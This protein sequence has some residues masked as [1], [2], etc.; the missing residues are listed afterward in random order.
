MA[1]TGDVLTR[2]TQI[3]TVVFDRRR[4]PFED[5]FAQGPDPVFDEDEIKTRRA[6][7]KTLFKNPA[8]HSLPITFEAHIVAPTAWV[9]SYKYG[10]ER[11]AIVFPSSPYLDDR[12]YWKIA[13]GID[14]T[15][16]LDRKADEDISLLHEAYH[17]VFPFSED[18]KKNDKEIAF[19]SEMLPDV[20]A[21]KT[22]LSRGKT[23][24]DIAQRKE[25]AQNYIRAR[26]ISAF[27]GQDKPEYSTAPACDA[28]LNMCMLPSFAETFGVLRELQIRTFDDLCGN[29]RNHWDSATYRQKCTYMVNF[30]IDGEDKTESAWTTDYFGI[31]LNACDPSIVMDALRTVVKSP[32]LSDAVRAEGRKILE[33]F[34]HFCPKDPAPVRPEIKKSRPIN[35]LSK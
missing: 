3:S 8:E 19:Q 27:F 14:V 1:I 33:A 23:K 5:R 30:K 35:G 28:A 18:A 20:S 34:D 9:Y 11:Y 6:A 2:L 32:G 24:D 29:N 10:S 13:I 12:A 21:L 7:F 25:A 4:L 17:L 16:K 15:Q 22:Y 31:S 26:R